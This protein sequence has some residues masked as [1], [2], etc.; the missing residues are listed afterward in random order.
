MSILSDGMRL[1][2]DEYLESR[3]KFEDMIQLN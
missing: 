1:L 2:N 3:L